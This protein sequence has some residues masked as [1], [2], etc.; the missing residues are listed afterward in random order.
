MDVSATKFVFPHTRSFIYSYFKICFQKAFEDLH[1]I[2]FTHMMQFSE[3]LDLT[4][5][6]SMCFCQIWKLSSPQLN[7]L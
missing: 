6:S 1:D 2:K 3:F 5:E 4:E 7:A